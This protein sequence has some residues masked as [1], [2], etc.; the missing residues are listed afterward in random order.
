MM[1]MMERVR[2]FR[3]SRCYRADALHPSLCRK[4]RYPACLPTLFSALSLIA[5]HP[6]PTLSTTATP[7]LTSTGDPPPK[8]LHICMEPLFTVWLHSY[9][10]CSLFGNGSNRK[11]EKLRAIMHY[12]KVMMDESKLLLNLMLFLS[13]THWW[14]VF[15]SLQTLHQTDWWRSRGV[16]SQTCPAGE[17]NKTNTLYF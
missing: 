15:M 2:V 3:P 1:V 5:T 7:P 11:K 6:N 8:V 4:F 14:S 13:V 17:S 16:A 12:F 9:S 10:A